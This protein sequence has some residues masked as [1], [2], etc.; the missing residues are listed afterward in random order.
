MFKVG[1]G[2][3]P[4][5]PVVYGFQCS[6]F[7]CVGSRFWVQIWHIYLRYNDLDF[8]FSKKNTGA[9]L[10]PATCILLL[11]PH[12]QLKTAN[13]LFTF[14]TRHPVSKVSLGIAFDAGKT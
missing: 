8:R 9:L 2:E 1:G 3:V 7:V 14:A 13:W 4:I 11:F 6:G 5:V 12:C 10:L